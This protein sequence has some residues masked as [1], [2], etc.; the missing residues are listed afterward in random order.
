MHFSLIFEI[1]IHLY[2]LIC[3]YIQC[4]QNMQMHI[5]RTLLITKKINEE[6]KNINE[7][8]IRKKQPTKHL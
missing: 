5:I 2:A 8:S 7:L 1:F 6:Q 3:I 4:S